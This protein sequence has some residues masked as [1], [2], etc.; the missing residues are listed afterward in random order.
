MGGLGKMNARGI[1]EGGGVGGGRN[2]GTL[3]NFF[4]FLMQLFQTNF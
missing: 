4:Q 1:E 2:V 3:M